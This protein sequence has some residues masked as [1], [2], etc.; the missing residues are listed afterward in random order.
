MARGLIPRG[1]VVHSIHL[2]SRGA[3]VRFRCHGETGGG[4]YITRGRSGEIESISN[5]PSKHVRGVRTVRLPGGVSVSGTGASVHGFAK[6]SRSRSEIACKP[7][8]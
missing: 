8:T 6:C 2:D 1:C 3:E 7:T 4:E 5:Y